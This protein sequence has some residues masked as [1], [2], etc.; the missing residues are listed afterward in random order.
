[1]SARRLQGAGIPGVPEERDGFVLTTT[2]A[3]A[4]VMRGPEQGPR[5]AWLEPASSD[6]SRFERPLRP[7]RLRPEQTAWLDH[8]PAWARPPAGFWRAPPWHFERHGP[9]LAARRGRYARD[10]RR[11]MGPPVKMPFALR[12]IQA[13]PP[14]GGAQCPGRRWEHRARPGARLMAQ[15]SPDT[16]PV[17]SA[18]A[19]EIAARAPRPILRGRSTS[20]RQATQW[21]LAN[22]SRCHN[23]VIFHEACGPPARKPPRWSGHH[24]LR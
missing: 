15:R 8:C 12:T 1:M 11:L 18:S 13:V 22:R 2:S 20:K 10:C 23:L 9:H 4:G 3:S 21:W 14:V 7:A 19:A 16:S 17:G 6:S 24:P 5:H